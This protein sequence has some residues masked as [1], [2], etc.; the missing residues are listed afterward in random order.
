MTRKALHRN[1]QVGE[2]FAMAVVPAT[3]TVLPPIEE[4]VLQRGHMLLID[5]VATCGAEHLEVTAC[6]GSDHPLADEHGIP[7]WVGL[8]LMAQAVLAFLGLELRAQGEAPRIGLLLGTRNYETHVPY[9]PAGREL[10]VRAAV[11]WRDDTGTGV[12][13]CSVHLAEG[14]GDDSSGRELA[15]A[16]VKG[17]APRD[18][19]TYLEAAIDG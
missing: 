1:A 2:N 16:K 3:N 15:R 8:E 5:R 14:R 9:F 10:R 18:I 11:A 17:F 12:F 13:D 7:C 4:L 19:E 6:L